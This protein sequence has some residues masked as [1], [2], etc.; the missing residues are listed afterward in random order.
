LHYILRSR[1]SAL[2]HN[3]AISRAVLVKRG[4]PP[5]GAKRY[6]QRLPGG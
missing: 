6:S 4:N 5:L 3:L 1:A 2:R